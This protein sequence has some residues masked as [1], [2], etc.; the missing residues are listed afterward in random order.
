MTSTKSQNGSVFFYILIAIILLAGLS[1]AVNNNSR[2]GTAIITEQQARVVSSQVLEQGEA[3]A[4][5]VQKL[6]LR[7]FDETEI[8]FEN[9]VVA[10]YGLASCATD[11]CKVFN[12]AGGALNWFEPPEGSNSDEDWVYSGD[13]PIADNGNNNVYDITMILPNVND[14]VCRQINFELNITSSINDPIPTATDATLGATK[15][16]TANPINAAS[17]VINGGIIDGNTAICVEIVNSS[18]E[19]TAVPNNRFFFVQTL[20]A[21]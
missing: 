10:G 2:V 8:S 9:S 19:L 1:Y 14:S 7:G 4:L 12:D 20:Y 3:M 21:G 11:D 16:S 13:L 6:L 18:G 17:E 5:A 15:L